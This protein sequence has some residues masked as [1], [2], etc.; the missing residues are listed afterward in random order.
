MIHDFF[1]II[2]SSFWNFCHFLKPFKS[3]WRSQM[4]H[5]FSD[6]SKAPET[7]RVFPTV[8]YWAHRRVPLNSLNFQNFLEFFS[9]S[10]RVFSESSGS[11]L[12]FLEI[13]WISRKF[14]HLSKTSLNF[15]DVPA[16]L[17]VSKKLYR[18]FGISNIVLISWSLSKLL[19]RYLPFLN[20]TDVC[21]NCWWYSWILLT[22]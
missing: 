17:W 2:R 6:P 21:L 3:S 8:L 10:F 22:Y 4:L 20:W 13:P 19:K 14:S 5:S 9:T 15:S 12:I 11:M 7:A 18:A 1:R 16:V